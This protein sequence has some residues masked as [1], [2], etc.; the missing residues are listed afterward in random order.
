MKDKDRLIKEL[1]EKKELYVTQQQQLQQ[2][3]AV[4]EGRRQQIE[5]VLKMLEENKDQK[6]GGKE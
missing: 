1:L 2:N 6:E 3:Y 4:L 5:E